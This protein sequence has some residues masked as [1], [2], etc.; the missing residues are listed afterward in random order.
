MDRFAWG[1][2]DVMS[3]A[4]GEQGKDYEHLFDAY[5]TFQGDGGYLESMTDLAGNSEGL[6]TLIHGT[7]TV[8]ERPIS[9]VRIRK[10]RPKESRYL[11]TGTI[12]GGEFIGG[13]VAFGVAE[14][15]VEDCLEGDDSLL[16][17]A[18]YY[19]VPVV[20]P[21][22]FERNVHTVEEG[23]MFGRLHRG[24]ANGVDLNRNFPDQFD[25]RPWTS[26]NRW[27]RWEYAGPEPFSEPESRF[28]RDVVERERITGAISYHS[29]LGV[30]LYPPFSSLDN[31]ERMADV[32]TRMVEAM[33]NG[34][35][36]VQGSSILEWAGNRVFPG[37]GKL[38]AR[39]RH[40]TVEGSFDGWLHK[41]G[42]P[43]LLV[44]VYRPPILMHSVSQLAAFNPP[45][46]EIESHVE[47][48]YRGAKKLFEVL[49]EG[50]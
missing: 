18:E 41:E 26:R 20:N 15:I 25:Y 17:E 28:L 48:Q 38:A 5:H 31:D 50:R 10:G 32:A 34:Y 19:V 30:V 45:G 44:E 23:K 35:V 24:N 39:V 11:I 27:L 1:M 46:N 21:D 2:R 42:I 16:R 40:P 36:P 8:E 33:G 12:H 4:W 37:L 47:T 29:S 14:K 43:S 49:L 7:R 9:M 3:Y 6:V 13:E 22:G